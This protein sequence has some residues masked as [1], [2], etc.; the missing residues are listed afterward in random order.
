MSKPAMWLPRSRN[1]CCSPNASLEHDGTFL[2][3][4]PLSAVAGSSPGRHSSGRRKS[5][6]QPAL[7]LEWDQLNPRCQPRTLSKSHKLPSRG[8]EGTRLRRL[9]AVERGERQAKWRSQSDSSA[10]SSGDSVCIGTAS[11]FSELW[12][13]KSCETGPVLG[14]S[15]WRMASGSERSRMR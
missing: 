15:S 6:L 12:S 14:A 7:S 3:L 10:K 2:F 5:V 8:E 9:P 11:T 1:T 13:S 4:K